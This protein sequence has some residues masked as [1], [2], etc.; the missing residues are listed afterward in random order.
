MELVWGGN[1][2][3][4][5]L[6]RNINSDHKLGES[7]ELCDHQR[8]ISIVTNGLDAG[9]NIRD[10]ISR[11]GEKL[12]G[13]LPLPAPGNRFP[14]M[15]KYID[16]GDSLS[17]QVHPDDNYGMIYNGEPGKTE[18]WY[19]LQAEPDSEII[20]GLI[21]NTSA[22]NF[23]NELNNGDPGKLLNRIKVKAGDSIYIP[24]GRIHAITKGVMILEI[25][26]N[27]DSTFRFYDWGRTGLDGKPREL[28][29]KEAFEVS[30]WNDYEPSMD[31]PTPITVNDNTKKT[32]AHCQYFTVDQYNI[33]SNIE[34]SSFGTTFHIIN[35]VSGKAKINWNNGVDDIYFG[36]TILVPASIDNFS[37]TAESQ[38]C[39]IVDSY[40][41]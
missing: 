9:M 27:S 31:H 12:L 36:E 23:T 30:K 28:H 3:N 24:A 22:E 38:N 34:I 2:F 13:T 25:Q 7:W 37:I 32:L 11:D 5:I 15:V 6:G 33:S 29:L 39:I 8:G 18:M 4:E 1:K 40:V 19:I 26:Q 16:A 20:A 14:L 41:S 17:V 35:C 21:K 10:I